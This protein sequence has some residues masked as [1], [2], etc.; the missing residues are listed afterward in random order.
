MNVFAAS[1][2]DETSLEKQNKNWATHLRRH[3]QL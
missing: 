2:G 1:E 3:H